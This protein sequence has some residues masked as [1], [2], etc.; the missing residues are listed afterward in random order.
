[1]VSSRCLRPTVGGRLGSYLRE[2]VANDVRRNSSGSSLGGEWPDFSK[3]TSCEFGMS[4]AMVSDI[5]T[6]VTQSCRPTVIRVGQRTPGRPGL[7]S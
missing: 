6:G 4:A 3:I 2:E 7:T 5:A 1:M